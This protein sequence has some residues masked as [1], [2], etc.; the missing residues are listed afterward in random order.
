[1]AYALRRGLGDAP[2]GCNCMAVSDLVAACG[3]GVSCD[4]RDSA[5]VANQAALTNWAENVQDAN[6]TG[7]CGPCI[8]AGTA[9]GSAPAASP[10]ETAT[11]M[12]NG[13]VGALPAGA[14]NG[15]SGLPSYVGMY[16]NPNQPGQTIYEWADC[17]QTT[18]P[19][20]GENPI[21][22]I[23][24]SAACAAPSPAAPIAP[25]TPVTVQTNPSG[26]TIVNSSGASGSTPVTP[27]STTSTAAASTSNWFTESLFDSI[28]NWALVAAAALGL[29]ALSSGGSHGR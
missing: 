20:Y 16:A 11:Y 10:A 19:V 23:Y 29:W 24:Q 13:P 18:S 4:P 28:P 27:A 5:C 21:A 15:P 2:A 7:G 14:P 3:G 1:M 9:C 22:P 12:A 6:W 25:P 17:T 26:S 8:P